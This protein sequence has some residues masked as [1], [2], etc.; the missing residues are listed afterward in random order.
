MN[1]TSTKYVPWEDQVKVAAALESEDAVYTM[2]GRLRGV[3]WSPI[4]N[5]YRTYGRTLNAN[6]MLAMKGKVY[7]YFVS[8]SL[9]SL[10]HVDQ[11]GYDIQC[12][13]TNVKVEVKSSHNLLLTNKRRVLKKTITFRM[14]NS[15]GS[16]EM[17]LNEENTADIYILVQQDAVAFTTREYV[18]AN[19]SAPNGGDIEAKI[20][21]EYVELLYKADEPVQLPEQPTINLPE[22]IKSIISCVNV[23]L[24]NNKDIREQLRNCLHQ[25]ADDL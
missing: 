1:N 2:I 12:S 9:P 19:M 7:E 22:I 5:I 23:A 20:P 16:G 11:L 4:C 13:E 24:W 3:D 18:L 8:N 21:N 15:N 10:V 14:K 25:I 6:D 17:S